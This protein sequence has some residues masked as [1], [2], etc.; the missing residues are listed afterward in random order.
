LALAERAAPE[1]HGARQRDWFQQ[2]RAER[3]NVRAAL[4]WS[5][6]H[7]AQADAELGLRLVV[8]L[9]DFWYFD[10][11]SVEGLMWTESALESAP[12]P[13]PATRA[14]AL[15]AAGVLCF[16]QG[17]YARMKAL[18][19]EA[20]ALSRE[21]GDE[22]NAA[23]ALIYLG[24]ASLPYPNECAEALAMTEQ[25]LALF[26]KHDDRV[27]MAIA[28]TILGELARV[29]GDYERA[30]I[31]YEECLALCREQSFEARE[32]ISLGNLGY[33]AQHNGD[34]ERAESLIKEALTLFW[35]T[36]RQRQQ[37]AFC[38]AALAGPVVAQ[39]DTERAARLLAASEAVLEALG[40]RRHA[41]D[42]F[43][44][45]RYIV[46]VREQ[47]DKATFEAAWAEGRAMSLEQAVSYALASG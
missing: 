24:G 1:L 3:D 42:Q 10:D 30:G 39:G 23:W 41:G 2:L 34:Y 14:S 26:R 16:P 12:N 28:L 19:S 29:D 47:L 35:Q 31:A 32:A 46:T 33:V 38:L 8:A 11:Y 25:G 21:L 9:R 18:L 7:T 37:I 36:T 22:I 4:A 13:P 27:G 44:V 15:N 40:L 20:L 43:E 6:G 5:L 17:D 45:E